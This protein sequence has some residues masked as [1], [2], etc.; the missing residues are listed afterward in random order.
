MQKIG[1]V[2]GFVVYVALFYFW[3]G[4]WIAVA[5]R[6]HHYRLHGAILRSDT[7]GQRRSGLSL[8]HVRC[9]IFYGS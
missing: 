8:A 1:T 2:T 4:E 3:S 6:W 9:G 7:G 5:R